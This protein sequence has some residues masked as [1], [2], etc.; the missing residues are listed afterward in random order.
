M[1]LEKLELY[2]FK[3]FAKRV[4][5][6]FDKGVTAIVGPNGSGKSNVADAIRWVLGEQSAKAL[7]G[8]RMEDVIFNGSE[9][10]R[11][12]AYCEV[13]LTFDN[14]DGTLP[15]E[16][17]EVTVMRRVYRSGES[18]YS[19]NRNTCR[20]RDVVDLFRDTGIGKEGYSIIGQGR[21][22]EILS[23]RSEERRVVFEEAAGI[24]KYKARKEEAEKKLFKTQENIQRLEDI[25]GE[26][27]DRLEPLAVQ[28]EKA[29]KYLA[30]RE[31][32]RDIDL[33]LFL[34]DYT[35][36]EEEDGQDALVWEQTEDE[37]MQ[38]AAEKN[39]A[40]AQQEI[41]A[42]QWEQLEAE[43]EKT[44]EKRLDW[45]AA[46]ERCEG[47]KRLLTERLAHTKEE[48]AR[49]QEALLTA[50]EEQSQIT[51]AL[52]SGKDL[53]GLR[54]EELVRTETAL[55]HESEKLAQQAEEIERESLALDEKRAALIDATNRR[56]NVRV[57]RTRL[58]SMD[59]S[60]A[61]Q[62][63]TAQKNQEN[64][65]KEWQELQN[66]LQQEVDAY[67]TLRQKAE[68]T[69]L[70]GENKQREL[71]GLCDEQ[72]KATTAL[73]NI[74]R[75]MAEQ[76]TRLSML[77]EMQRDY[78]GFYNSVRR[79][80]QDA[81]QDAALG[82][83]ILGAVAE[84]IEVPAQ[85]EAAIESAL[86]GQL[87]NIVTKDDA[88]AK[89]AIAHLR[90]KRYGRATFLPLSTVQSRTLN[91]NERNSLR[92][93]GVLG[94][95]SELVD[96]DPQYRMMVEHL[97]GR[98]VIVENL[99]V[100]TALARANGQRFRLATLEG[101][102]INPGGAMTGGSR[103]KSEFSLLGREREREERKRLLQEEEAKAR[104]LAATASQNEAMIREH[105]QE[106]AEL[107]EE[108]KQQQLAMAR[109]KEKSE[110]LLRI[111]DNAEQ[112][113]QKCCDAYEQ[114]VSMRADVSRQKEELLS[115]EQEQDGEEGAQEAIAQSQH[116][117]YEKR[118]RR[119]E[120]LEILSQKQMAWQRDKSDWHSE[121][122]ERERREKELR[123]LERQ[124]TRDEA[125]L[126]AEQERA[127]LTEAELV[128]AERAL[129]EKQ[130]ELV[131]IQQSQEE[132]VKRR[133]TLAEQRQENEKKL[134]TL[135]EKIRDWED[136]RQKIDWKRQRREME[137]DAL[138][139]RIWEE[140]ELSIEGAKSYWREDLP[141]GAKSLLDSTREQIR[142]LGEV[143]VN[144]IEDY[145]E[146][147][148]RFDEI[149][150]QKQD[151][152]QASSDLNALIAELVSTMDQRFREQFEKINRNFG[153][154]FHELF[155]GGRAE[156][157]LGDGQDALNS[158]IEI[159]AQPP[160]KNLQLL[161]LLS[162]GE[163]ALTAIALLFSMLQLKPTPFCILDEIEA[164]LDEANVDNF[165][166]YVKNYSEK[167]QFILITH[168]KGSMVV[169]DSLYGVA[170]QGKG[171]SQLVSV[172]LSEAEQLLDSS[173]N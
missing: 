170:M 36:M 66:D 100:G 162:G 74:E 145:R 65:K 144:A 123:V 30:L 72:E 90:S 131:Q 63:E 19:I 153:V 41:L 149:S 155:G 105:R 64:R 133:Q 1:R 168:R 119:E 10:Q 152:E 141:S 46:Q 151:L 32:I 88:A 39:T 148:L 136:R 12:Q 4:E 26:L 69:R 75:S 22:D 20:L 166:Q 171:V 29:E 167:T 34:R 40:A 53:F 108:R 161:S 110:S 142:A 5:L 50:T 102:I 137:R 55:A 59:E 43:G 82:E 84:C 154:T 48:H 96:Y 67:E 28:S 159:I 81:K 14:S 117:L 147:R 71:N 118:Q 83:G 132:W 114:I 130:E 94:V 58:E 70:L 8:G 140:Y 111:C 18:E 164:S 91:D 101:D 33:N 157:R 76:K 116:E 77:E 172:R 93:D 163:R 112:E 98:T 122:R 79:L 68:Q 138:Q 49:L 158:D 146:L 7:R 103:Q 23:G 124:M 127:A 3:S 80:L 31:T 45:T 16:Y 139:K 104:K 86:G 107:E 9:G 113:W 135:R 38:M 115:T 95:A 99:D 6:R 54:E 92:R 2:G 156:L 60:L 17:N 37:G 150:E 21:V 120:A 129:Q 13:A 25:L 128:E 106:N 47:E 125:S 126:L 78:E 56:A 173:A 134:D 89:R 27:E 160:G 57:Q 11:A 15:I 121:T 109:Q 44:N 73:R 42:G 87:Q 35:R 24:S 51:E 85:I 61:A 169:A 97:L 62:E 52:R 165:A 143:N